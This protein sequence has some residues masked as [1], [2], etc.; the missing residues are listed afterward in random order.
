MAVPED[1]KNVCAVRDFIA[2][3]GKRMKQCA[4]Q[5]QKR[6]SEHLDAG[7]VS[8]QEFALLLALTE[9]GTMAV[10]DIAARLPG[11]SLSTL[12]RILDKLE[13]NGFVTRALDPEDRRSFLITGTGKARQAADA[14]SR[15]M[16]RVAASMLDAL[17]QEERTKLVELLGKIRTHLNSK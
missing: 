15:Q 13:D 6:C 10:K 17:E 1:H 7:K 2:D 8:S 4:E 12:T 14:Y 9:H 16:D 3:I 5:H 11:I